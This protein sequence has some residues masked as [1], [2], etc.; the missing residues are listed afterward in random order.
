[1]S[2]GTL[3]PPLSAASHRNA[4]ILPGAQC[5]QVCPAAQCIAHAQNQNA[6]LCRPTRSTLFKGTKRHTVLC[7]VLYWYNG[8]SSMADSGGVASRGLRRTRGVLGITTKYRD[9]EFKCS[10]ILPFKPKCLVHT[11]QHHAHCVTQCG[12]LN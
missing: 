12:G 3:R 9:G 11:L 5:H 8:T 2:D 4:G 7:S 6:V 10:E 1:M